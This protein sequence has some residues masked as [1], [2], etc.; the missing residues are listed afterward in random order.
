MFRNVL[1][2][3]QQKLFQYNDRNYSWECSLEPPGVKHKLR[4]HAQLKPIV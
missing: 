4:I 3:Q 1:Q 2:I